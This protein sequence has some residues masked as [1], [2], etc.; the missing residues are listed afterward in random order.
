MKNSYKHKGFY[1]GYREINKQP[2]LKNQ[3]YGLKKEDSTTT[4]PNRKDKQG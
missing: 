3:Y 4:K 2:I 1:P